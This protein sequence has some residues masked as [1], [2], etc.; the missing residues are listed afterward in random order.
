MQMF[1]LRNKLRLRQVL[2]VTNPK[3]IVFL[4]FWLL[5]ILFPMAWL[6]NFSKSYRQ[7]F[8]TIFAPEWMHWL[9]HAALYAGLAILLVLVFTL[10][11]NRRTVV[12]V[13]GIV[14]VV[15]LIQEGMQ[16]FSAVQ[17]VSWNSFL[18]LGVD[19]VGAAIGLG[20]IW[21]IRKASGIRKSPEA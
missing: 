1:K 11:L 16:L 21:G 13:L 14:L 9:M 2:S 15:G 5:G 12:L 3:S 6:G 10:P 20:V 8:N 7:I 19:L 17:I 4:L 18:D